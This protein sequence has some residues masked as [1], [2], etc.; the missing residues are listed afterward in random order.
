[1][2]KRSPYSYCIFYMERKYSHLIK[3]ELIEWGYDDLKVVIPMVKILKRTVKG[4]MVFE[5]VPILFNYGF[6]RIPTE[7]A[8]SRPYLTKLRRR[9]SGIRTWLRSTETMHE[10]KKKIRIDNSEDFDDFSLVATCS[11]K[12]VRRFIRMARANKKYS[13]E[14]LMNVKPGDYIILKGYPY[15][16]IDSTVLDVNYTNKTVK[17]LIY[18][19]HGKMEVNLD[20]DSVLYSVY[21]NSDPDKLYCNNLD[22]DPNSITSES[23]EEN[24]NK[25]RR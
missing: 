3:K 21:Q 4:K 7:K 19:E 8:Y 20:F 12:D 22:Y 10:R 14:D 18:P 5:E 15:E 13:I 17:V 23:I 16:G 6:M 24:I 11:R 9:I 25:R 2:K 1:M